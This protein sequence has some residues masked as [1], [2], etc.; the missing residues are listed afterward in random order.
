M[1]AKPGP[2]D[3]EIAYLSGGS[4]ETLA[5]DYEVFFTAGDKTNCPVTSCVLSDI[6]SC[7]TPLEKGGNVAIGSD[8]WAITAK[9][10]NTTG[11]TSTVC[12]QCSIGAHTFDWKGKTNAGS[13]WKIT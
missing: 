10:D 2:E 5:A 4:D 3:V 1:T 12:V 8:P 13:G 11:Y 9:Q 6:R 7:G